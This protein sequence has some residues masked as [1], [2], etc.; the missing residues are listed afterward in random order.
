MNNI[1]IINFSFYSNQLTYCLASIY[2][3]GRQSAARGPTSLLRAVL[4]VRPA[5]QF[6]IQNSTWR[7]IDV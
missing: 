1:D 3:R 2:G 4:R 5:G 7:L 6:L